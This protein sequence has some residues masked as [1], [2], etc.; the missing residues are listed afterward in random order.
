MDAN[1]VWTIH[2]G[3][4]LKVARTMP[5][6]SVHCIATSPPYWGLR[7]YGA[8]GQL[9]LERNFNAYLKRMVRIFRE[10]R[11]VL[12]KDGTLWLNMGDCYNAYNGNRGTASTFAG[13]RMMRGEPKLKTGHGLMTKRLK[14]KDLVGQPWRLALALQADGWFLRADCIW[15]KPNPMPESVRDRPTKS[16]EYVFILSKSDRYFYDQHAVREPCGR[17][18]DDL[19]TPSDWDM[20]SG[21]HDSKTENYSSGNRARKI[22]DPTRVND[23]KGWAFPWTD[24][25]TGRNLRSVWTV[26]TVAFDAEFCTAC[27]VLYDGAAKRT[28]REMTESTDD[29]PKVRRFCRCGRSDSWLSHF[30]TFPRALVE[31]CI[32]AG[33]SEAGVCANCAAPFERVVEATPEY[34]EA[35]AAAPEEWYQR[36]TDPFG[37]EKKSGNKQRITAD[38]VTKRWRPTCRCGAGSLGIAHPPV[39]LDPFCGSGT[40]AVVALRLGRSFIGIELKPDYVRL[41]RARILADA[42]LFNGPASASPPA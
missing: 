22:E 35:L 1:P 16:H 2:E 11:R 31:R 40:T 36:K 18:E 26:P 3:D 7:D 37:G 14:P 41:A 17:A 39:V 32:K 4:V 38:Y 33:T 23:H 13:H 6:T 19:P 30:A 25:G 12:R 8:T 20:G 29:G 5:S 15:H 27:G 34:A 42:P 9:G 24:E 21:S 10:L 28:L